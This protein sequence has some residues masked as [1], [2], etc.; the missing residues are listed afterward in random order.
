MRKS[1][2]TFGA[3]A[4]AL[5]IR[6]RLAPEFLDHFNVERYFT[7]RHCGK[8]LMDLLCFVINYIS[9]ASVVVSINLIMSSDNLLKIWCKKE[10]G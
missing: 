1:I 3:M 10:K 7:E 2:S 9:D 5:N 8:G 4:A 6:F